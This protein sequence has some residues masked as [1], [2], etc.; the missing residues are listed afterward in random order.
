MGK[1]RTVPLARGLIAGETDPIYGQLEISLI[2]NKDIQI[3]IWRKP[4]SRHSD[5]RFSIPP[6]SLQSLVDVFHEARERLDDAW[7]SR[8]ATT[9][10][11]TN[12]RARISQIRK[13]IAKQTTKR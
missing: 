8:V 1:P 7:L 13:A 12:P 10:L 11:G 6:T 2:N 9:E 3:T 5:I 4:Y